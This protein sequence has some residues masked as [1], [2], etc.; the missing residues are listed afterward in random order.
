MDLCLDEIY[1]LL[2]A[3]R[4]GMTKDLVDAVLH[5][6]DIVPTFTYRQ[7]A[8]R[9]EHDRRFNVFK[10]QICSLKGMD[11]VTLMLQKLRP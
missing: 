3:D 1:K 11:P 6:M 5:K 2:A 7:I 10:G 9:M 4:V 8:E